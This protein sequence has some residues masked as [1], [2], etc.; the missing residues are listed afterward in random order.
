MKNPSLFTVNLVSNFLRIANGAIFIIVG[1]A[2]LFTAPEYGISLAGTVILAVTLLGAFIEERWIF[3]TERES[4]TFRF[5][6][7]FFAHRRVIPFS[8]IAALEF[9]D[10][11][12]GFNKQKWTRIILRIPSGKDEILDTVNK[13]K[14]ADLIAR[15]ERLAAFFAAR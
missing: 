4:A 9:D 7:V 2:Q 14:A 10:F 1:A 15:A 5:G 11:E 12:K 13:A 6:L 3:D 8:E